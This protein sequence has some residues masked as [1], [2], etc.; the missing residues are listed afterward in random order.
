[1]RTSQPR[2]LLTVSIDL[3]AGPTHLVGHRR[4]N[5]ITIHLLDI[6][7]KHQLP[8]TWSTG[9]PAT[10]AASQVVS[11]FAGHE[12]AILGDASWVGCGAGRQ[13][14][15][16]ELASRTECARNAGLEISTLVL[17]ATELGDQC[18]LAIKHGLTAVRHSAVAGK[19]ARRWRASTLR[20]GLWSFPVSCALPGSSRWLPGGGGARSAKALVDSAIAERGL[21]QLAIDATGLEARGASALRVLHRVFE[22]ISLR[23]QQRALDVTTIRA[24]AGQLSEQL[25]GQPS[26]SILRAA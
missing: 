7:A 21:F 20:F 1:M 2:A 16:R 15:G 6:L 18:D 11:R 23:R 14:F 26:Q 13:R 17:H 22:H 12:I 24:A 5:E 19:S 10:S 9:D 3:E 4:L 25:H 8:G